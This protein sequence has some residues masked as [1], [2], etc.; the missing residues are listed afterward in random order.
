MPLVDHLQ[1]DAPR[2]EGS[3]GGQGRPRSSWPASWSPTSSVPIDGKPLDLIKDKKL[4]TDP[5]AAAQ[6]L[7]DVVNGHMK[8]GKTRARAGAAATRSGPATARRRQLHRLPQPVHLAGAV[9][10]DPGQ[11]RDRLPAAARSTAAATS[12]AITAGRSSVRGQG[13]G[14]GGHLRGEQE[15]EDEGLLL[16]Q[17]DRGPRRLQH[18]PRPDAGAQAGRRAAA[19]SS[20]TPTSRWTARSIPQAKIEKKFSYKDEK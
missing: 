8:Y 2:G 3:Q 9:A 7:Y 14:A 1:G 18:R 19:T 6:V 16:R 10:E 15:P 17:P 12:P 4:P 11:V 5:T 20:S 13:L